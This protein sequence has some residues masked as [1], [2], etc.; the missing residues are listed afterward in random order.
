MHAENE[1]E[2]EEEEGGRGEKRETSVG[3]SVGVSLNYCRRTFNWEWE[4][5]LLLFTFSSAGNATRQ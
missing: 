1:E 3:R 4:K 5:S 2:E